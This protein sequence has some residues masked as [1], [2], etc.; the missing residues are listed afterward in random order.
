MKSGTG[1]IYS[2]V[3]A[4]V[5]PLFILTIYVTFSRAKS[6]ILS[7]FHSDVLLRSRDLRMYVLLHGDGGGNRT[8]GAHVL[9]CRMS[10]H[11]D[12]RENVPCSIKIFIYSKNRQTGRLVQ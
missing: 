7:D 2:A 11:D 8:P 6:T 3:H 9:L 12:V 1:S 10:I 5:S 4:A